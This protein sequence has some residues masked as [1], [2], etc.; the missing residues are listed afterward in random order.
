MNKLK[1]ARIATDVANGKIE[2]RRVPLDFYKNLDE[3]GETLKSEIDNYINYLKKQCEG[4]EC[5]H[6]TVLY[7]LIH[8]IFDD[9]SK[10][11]KEYQEQLQ[12]ERN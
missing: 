4:H 2:L 11:N 1:I 5:T 8:V 12:I 6:A 10:D 3:L 7:P 9:L